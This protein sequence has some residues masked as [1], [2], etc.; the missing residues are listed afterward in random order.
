MPGDEV[1][2]FRRLPCSTPMLPQRKGKGKTGRPNCRPAPSPVLRYWPGQSTQGDLLPSANH[3]VESGTAPAVAASLTMRGYLPQAIASPFPPAISAAH[4]LACS[5]LPSSVR[6]RWPAVVWFGHKSTNW[7]YER[8][9]V[10]AS[11]LSRQCRSRRES[12]VVNLRLRN[13]RNR[14]PAN[15]HSAKWRWQNAD[16]DS[17]GRNIGQSPSVSARPRY[18]AREWIPP[19]ATG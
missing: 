5:C 4:A 3:G 9:S 10:T 12:Q 8:I 19:D 13:G 15:R 14:A 6:E 18:L 7:P 16:P 1:A 2:A 11:P 17:P